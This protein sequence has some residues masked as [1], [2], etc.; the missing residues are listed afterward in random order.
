MPSEERILS[1]DG[2]LLEKS[3][4]S[5]LYTQSLV[6]NPFTHNPFTHFPLYTIL[7]G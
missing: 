6:H 5:E 3:L 7:E 2:L 4:T 1:E